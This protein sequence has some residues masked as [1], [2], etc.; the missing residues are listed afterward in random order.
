MDLLTNVQLSKPNTNPYAIL[1]A[2][3]GQV[4]TAIG[5]GIFQVKTISV[6]AYVFRDEDLVHNLL[7]IAP[8]ADCGCT[9]VFTAH[10]FNLYHK[11]VR[12]LAGK[13][14]SANLWHIS[15]D[16]SKDLPIEQHPYAA[17]TCPPEPEDTEE[18]TLMF[19]PFADATSKY[20]AARAA[21]PEAGDKF[22][23]QLAPPLSKQTPLLHEGTRRDDKYVQFV[24]RA[25][26][27]PPL[28]PS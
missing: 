16:E 12:L 3:N 28:Q 1:R 23:D 2:A 15:L 26:G 25:W 13:R 6:V 8:F 5:K 17:T 10:D 21:Q 11:N 9:A 18:M 27:V 7:G 14:H 22:K 4:L 20:E 19:R 24:M